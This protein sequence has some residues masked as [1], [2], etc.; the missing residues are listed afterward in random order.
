MFGYVRPLSPELRVRELDMFKALY[1]GLC[2]TLGRRYGVS[3]R[4]ILSYDFVFLCAL[5]W[6]PEEKPVFAQRRCPAGL[7]KKRCTDNENDA[8][9]RAAGYGVILAWHKLLDNRR[10][11][12]F[13]KAFAARLGMLGLR[14][15]Y[16]KAARDYPE[17]DK[18]TRRR[19]NEL[20]ELEKTPGAPPDALAD[21]FA[22]LLAD[23]A[24]L[25]DDEARRRIFESLLYHL[26]RWLY[27]IDARDDLERDIKD[28]APNPLRSGLVD[29]TALATTLTHSNSL[30]SAAFELLPETPWSDI[31]RNIIYLGLPNTQN[32]VLSGRAGPGRGYRNI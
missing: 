5:L 11:E 17:F 16:K 13:F 10:D 4:F 19:L 23:A 29:D 25:E 3:A 26:G 8:T 31:S 20:E 27:Y 18:S 30:I 15:A 6:P 21:A 14:A 1:C 12:G 7:R 32:G 2:H 28:G 9:A 24:G 22:G